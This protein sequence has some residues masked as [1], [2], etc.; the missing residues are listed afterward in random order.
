MNERFWL[1]SSQDLP[2]SLGI[3][4][5]QCND[6]WLDEP[7]K[8]RMLFSLFEDKLERRSRVVRWIHYKSRPLK[9]LSKHFLFDGRQKSVSNVDGFQGN[10]ETAKAKGYEKI[11]V[12]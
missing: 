5:V 12:L 3:C 4:L 11:M 2:V 10:T 8:G 7:V 6:K 9:F 1:K